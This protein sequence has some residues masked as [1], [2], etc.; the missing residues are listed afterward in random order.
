MEKF[1]L[2]FLLFIL[3]FF[4]EVLASKVEEGHLVEHKMTKLKFLCDHHNVYR[5]TSIAREGSKEP[6][7]E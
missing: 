2:F 6:G 5:Q 7:S 1:L 3:V 4:C